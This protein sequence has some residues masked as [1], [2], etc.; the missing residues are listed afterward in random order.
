[1]NKYKR[2][3]FG[4]ECDI[5]GHLNNASYLNLY[6]EARSEVLDNLGH[7]I[8]KLMEQGIFLYLTRI[9]IQ[10][11]KEVNLGSM[12][13][14]TTKSEKTTKVRFF[15]YQEIHNES[16]DLCNSAQIEGAFVKNGRPYRI[17]E[18]M[19][20]HFLSIQD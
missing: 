4:F 20:D 1:M 18:E 6:E 9:D 16:G 10:F 19:L 13:T 14:I 12:I 3:I 2:K 15:W 11:K 5:Y 8:A 17:P 7:P